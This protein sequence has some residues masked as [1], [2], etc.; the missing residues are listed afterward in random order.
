MTGR[1]YPNQKKRATHTAKSRTTP[2]LMP[3]YHNHRETGSSSFT[4]V[5]G[6]TADSVAPSV[7]SQSAS[8]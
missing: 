3:T 7:C 1:I 5:S 6:T 8:D 4:T 2:T